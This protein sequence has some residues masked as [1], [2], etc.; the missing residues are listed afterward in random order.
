MKNGEGVSVVAWHG[1]A[2][3]LGGTIIMR[4]CY[5][6]SCTDISRLGFFSML[7]VSTCEQLQSSDTHSGVLAFLH[8]KND[9]WVIFSLRD[10]ADI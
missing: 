6:R 7:S 10:G 8:L 5:P 3:L 2:E 1:M 4:E 9:K